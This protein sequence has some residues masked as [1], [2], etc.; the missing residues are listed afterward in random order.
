MISIVRNLK[1]KK[2]ISE[3]VDIIE[4]HANPMDMSLSNLWELRMEREAWHAA[5]HGVTKIWTQLND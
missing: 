4:W 5:V 1:K 2:K 3:R